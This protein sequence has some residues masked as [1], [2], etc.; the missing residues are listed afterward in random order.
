MSVPATAPACRSHLP[1]IFYQPSGGEKSSLF[2]SPVALLRFS[3]HRCTDILARDA[4]SLRAPLCRAASSRVSLSPWCLLATSSCSL[5][6]SRAQLFCRPRPAS[7][8]RRSQLSLS[9]SPCHG[10]RSLIGVCSSSDLLPTA[11][12]LHGCCV[13]QPTRP[14]ESL[15]IPTASSHGAPARGVPIFFPVVGALLALWSSCALS[16]RLLLIPM[17]RMV[18]RLAVAARCEAPSVASPSSQPWRFF[19]PRRRLATRPS[20][21]HFVH[22]RCPPS[23]PCARSCSSNWSLIYCTVKSLRSV[24]VARRVAAWC[25]AYCFSARELFYWRPCSPHFPWTSAHFAVA[26]AAALRCS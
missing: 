14:A 26:L 10:R 1:V 23:S 2:L 20:L 5:P 9:P 4:Y 22:G 15:S 19:Q 11:H 3:S 21:R 16:T 8:P 25:R 18:L 17:P 12:E 6:W 24:R 7:H 13:L